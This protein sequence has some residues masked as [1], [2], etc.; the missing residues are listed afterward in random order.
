MKSRIIV[1]AALVAVLTL[2]TS[3]DITH[4]N[5]SSGLVTQASNW[6]I[7]L[8]DKSIDRV[9]SASSGRIQG[10]GNDFSSKDFLFDNSANVD[11]GSSGL[12]LTDSSMFF[13]GNSSMMSLLGGDVVLGSGIGGLARI[14][15]AGSSIV[16]G[17]ENLT[18]GGGSRGEIIQQSGNVIFQNG[19][20]TLGGDT[21]DKRGKY[22]LSG[23]IVQVKD[24][25]FTYFGSQFNFTRGSRG[26][27]MVSTNGTTVQELKTNIHD[28]NITLND[29]TVDPDT[30]FNVED[31][32]N[33]YI[34][35]EVIIPEPVVAGLLGFSGIGFIFYRR[36][37]GHHNEGSTG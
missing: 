17:T 14:T 30:F 1:S 8:P 16:V 36:L 33:G 15:V 7:G 28:G 27:L 35:V 25:S 19:V 22:T 2:S 37:F 5:G 6:S 21:N 26:I 32:G 24:I 12:S 31:K 10:G 9:G 34:A 4:W 23:G 18:L 3:G 29:Q 11:I 20:L 13:S